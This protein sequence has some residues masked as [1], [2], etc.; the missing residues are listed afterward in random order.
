MKLFSHLSKQEDL[1]WQWS[2]KLAN[3][4]TLHCVG[5]LRII[6]F[7]KLYVYTLY[8][9]CFFFNIILSFH[10]FPNRLTTWVL[11]T[12]MPRITNWTLHIV[13]N[14]YLSILRIAYSGN[15][16]VIVAR[17]LFVDTGLGQEWEQALSLNIILMSSKHWYL[18]N[19]KIGMWFHTEKC[20]LWNL[21]GGF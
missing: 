18:F 16:C 10:H 7:L 14:A 6:F 3:M 11:S 15:W 4:M 20:N 8:C 12:V 19:M 13:S 1:L 2:L 21:F 17:K 9:M 5:V